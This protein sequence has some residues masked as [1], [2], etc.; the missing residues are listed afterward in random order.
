MQTTINYLDIFLDVTFDE[1]PDKDIVI[2]KICIDK[3]DIYNLI[4][5]KHI[6][7]LTNLIKK[8]YAN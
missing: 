5:S 6:E 2:E 4:Q 7:E 1:Y 8:K 3:I